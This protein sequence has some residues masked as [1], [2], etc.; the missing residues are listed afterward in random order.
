[1]DENAQNQTPEAA[2]PVQEQAAVPVAPQQ[3]ISL[4]QLIDLAIEKEA[5]DIPTDKEIKIYD[6]YSEILQSE[7]EKYYTAIDSGRTSRYADEFI[8]EEIINKE[9]AK[10][11]GIT[12]DE[13]DELFIRVVKYKYE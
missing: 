9:T 10:K 4:D 7:T 1:M 11:Y 12:T 8:L 6:Y 5:S 13:L 3:K 2:A